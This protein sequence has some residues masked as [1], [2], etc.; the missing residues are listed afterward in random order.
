M[1]VIIILQKLMDN[2]L[3]SNQNLHAIKDINYIV[4]TNDE[5]SGQAQRLADY[6]Q[7]NSGLTTQVVLLSQ[8]YNEFGSGSPDITAIRDFIKHVYTTN[9][10]N[11]GN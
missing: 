2:S 8:I 10:N 3:V 1:I 11:Q 6:H 4:I 9:S 5:L 7:K